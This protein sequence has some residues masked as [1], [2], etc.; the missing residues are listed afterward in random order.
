MNILPQEYYLTTI[1][2]I[3]KYRI[4]ICILSFSIFLAIFISFFGTNSS[5]FSEMDNQDWSLP[6]TPE[7]KLVSEINTILALPLFGGKPEVIEAIQENDK[8]KIINGKWQIIGIIE[9]GQEKFALINDL[10]N[11]KIIPISVGDLFPNGEILLE[12]SKNSISVKNKDEVRTLSLF[13]K[14][15]YKE[16]K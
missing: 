1:R 8:N 16:N 4:N 5:L 14:K 10:S 3:N 15:L 9:D 7:I 6:I 2:Q 11:D 13:N 12:I